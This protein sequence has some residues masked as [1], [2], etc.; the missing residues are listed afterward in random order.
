VYREILRVLKPG[1]IFATYEW[2]ITD[3]FDPNNKKHREVKH[4]IEHGNGIP[5]LERPGAI[6]KAV[7]VRTVNN[8]IILFTF[9]SFLFF[10]SFFVSRD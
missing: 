7:R 6:L 9:F 10:F 2:V 3:K 1:A 8:N 5:E 4:A